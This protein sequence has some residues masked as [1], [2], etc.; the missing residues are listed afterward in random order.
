MPISSLYTDL[1][2]FKV[3]PDPHI[4]LSHHLYIILPLE[5]HVTPTSYYPSIMM[6]LHI[7]MILVAIP[8]ESAVFFC[9][10]EYHPIRWSSQGPL[11]S[12]RLFFTNYKWDDFP[13]KPWFQW[14]NSTDEFLSSPKKPPVKP[15]LASRG[16]LEA[17]DHRCE[18]IGLRLLGQRRLLRGHRIPIWLVVDLPLWKIWVRQLGWLYIIIPN[19]WDN[20]KNVP[21]HQPAM[22]LLR[23]LDDV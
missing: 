15:W 22:G 11:E 13:S 14:G 21:N 3:T 18:A 1:I 16:P 19:I 6:C 9:H 2:P 20:K 23:V 12:G 10:S 17:G 4:H 8:L 5:S 7:N